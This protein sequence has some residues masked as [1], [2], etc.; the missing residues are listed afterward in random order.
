MF[1]A[2]QP[3]RHSVCRLAELVRIRCAFRHCFGDGV[4]R[5]DEGRLAATR[6]A[7][8]RSGLPDAIG[9]GLD[10]TRLGMPGRQIGHARASSAQGRDPVRHGLLVMFPT[11]CALE[12]GENDPQQVP[13][14]HVGHFGQHRVDIRWPKA[15]ADSHRHAVALRVQIGGYPLGL[16]QRERVERRKASEHV[17]VRCHLVD[18]RLGARP[19]TD[20]RAH[21]TGRFASRARIIALAAARCR[22]PESD[23]QHAVDGRLRHDGSCALNSWTASTRA[24]TLSTGV[25]GRMPC[26]RLKTCPA[27]PAAWRRIS[28]TR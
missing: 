6:P 18:P 15:H 4:R 1:P 7:K 14:A 25:V 23:Q 8:Q 3:F 26:P 24:R 11:G 9:N 17:V 5:V 12:W 22:A 10:K 2:A 20:N 16:L 27:R 13:A 21:K 28:R 19:L